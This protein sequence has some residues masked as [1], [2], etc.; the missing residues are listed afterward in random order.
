MP[1]NIGPLYLNIVNKIS[2]SL[3]NLGFQVRNHFNDIMN[4]SADIAYQ[5]YNGKTNLMRYE[6]ENYSEFYMQMQWNSL[7][8]YKKITW[9][10]ATILL[11]WI[12]HGNTKRLTQI[13]LIQEIV[14]HNF[15]FL[16]AMLAIH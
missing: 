16:N 12:K 13:Y 3:I 7:T 10:K 15:L 8:V 11:H 9:N 4:Y 2:T 6:Q 14:F 5:E 1:R